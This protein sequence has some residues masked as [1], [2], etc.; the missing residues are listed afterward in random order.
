MATPDKMVSRMYTSN[1]DQTEFELTV[2]TGDDGSEIEIT[3][4][5]FLPVA[6]KVGDEKKFILRGGIY[7]IKVSIGNSF[8]E[9][10]I[11]LSR[12][13]RVVFDTIQFASAAPLEETSRTDIM[14][15][16]ASQSN[17]T[18]YHLHLGTGSAVY[19]F[20]RDWTTDHEKSS[21]NIQPDNHP[22]RGLKL[23]DDKGADLVNLS[24]S[25]FPHY[26]SGDESWSACNISVNPGFY[27]LSLDIGD[28]ETLEMNIVASPG[29]QTQVF[30]LQRD[31]GKKRGGRKADLA[32]AS[33][34]LARLG[35]GFNGSRSQLYPDTQ[36]FRMAEIARQGL[37]N[38][39]SVLSDKTIEYMLNEKFSSPML[40]IYGA[41]LLLMADSKE[42]NTIEMVVKNL[43]RV[44]GPAHPD[45]EALALRAGTS[46]PFVFSELPM[47][48]KSWAYVLN[49]STENPGLVPEDSF[50]CKATQ[51]LWSE[52]PW[53]IWGKSKNSSNDLAQTFFLVSDYLQKNKRFEIDSEVK[54]PDLISGIWKNIKH[55]NPKMDTKLNVTFHNIIN[56]IDPEKKLDFAN[57]KNL[58]G[59]DMEQLVRITQSPQS[60]VNSMLDAINKNYENLK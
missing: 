54:E 2:I 38:E 24:D 29:W 60:V 51:Q 30:L 49:A 6:R 56:E 58:T 41:H 53:L 33:I 57:I 16:G 25:A 36:N 7:G 22:A 32:N 4:S 15:S 44:L 18:S 34:F 11:H 48:R 23:V 46:T 8:E 14:Q 19:I 12:N 55:Y 17:S 20:C 43:R 9:K 5:Q 10:T 47:L 1:T 3:D 59:K 37:I 31:Y 42:T 28:E 13:E 35:E 39:R 50:A 21:R 40:G 26:L 45:V 27:R 52:G